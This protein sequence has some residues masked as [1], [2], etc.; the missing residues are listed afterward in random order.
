MHSSLVNI[1]DY[2]VQ[3]ECP[4]KTASQTSVETRDSPFSHNLPRC[5]YK[6]PLALRRLDARLDDIDWVDAC[7]CCS[8][9]NPASNQ[10]VAEISA[11]LVE[12]KIHA[13]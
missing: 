4:E 9:G 11:P 12:S 6:S 2:P 13:K 10:G 5:F 7:P 1:K 8:P 3:C